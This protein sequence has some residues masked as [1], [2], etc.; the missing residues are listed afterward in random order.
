MHTID[1][2]EAEKDY[3]RIRV[4]KNKKMMRSKCNNNNNNKLQQ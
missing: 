1:D 2:G 4:Y 3:N